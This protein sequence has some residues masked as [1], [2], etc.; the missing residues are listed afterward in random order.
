MNTT[1]L[2]STLLTCFLATGIGFLV[3][4]QVAAFSLENTFAF[5]LKPASSFPCDSVVSP[6]LGYVVGVLNQDSTA[7]SLFI[8]HD[9]SE[10]SVVSVDVR[11]GDPC[12][13]GAALFVTPLG[14]SPLAVEWQLAA[15]DLAQLVSGNLF[16]AI[17]SP[18][19]PNG[20][21]LGR[22]EQKPDPHIFVFNMDG[23]QANNCTSPDGPHT[24]VGAVF[25]NQDSTLI[26]TFMM[27]DI[28]VDSIIYANV[29]E[30]P[31]CVQGVP[32]NIYDPL[33]TAMWEPAILDSD[34]VEYLFK[35]Y[36]FSNIHTLAY[37]GAEIRGQFLK[38]GPYADADGDGISDSDDLCPG[39]A[40]NICCCTVPGD[41]D[42][43]GKTNIADI[44]FLIARI[45]AGGSAPPCCQEGDVN[46]S[47]MVNIADVTFLIARIFAGGT[48]PL[49]GPA[50]MGC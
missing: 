33:D 31:P 35:G 13:T 46:R 43:S 24:G 32:Y 18:D 28:A 7:F 23:P 6:H 10:D 39:D 19:F 27:H 3:H 49:C 16:V 48:A 25:L 41:A 21:I 14:A 42:N 37:P 50:G 15:G 44:T 11:T 22:I 9:L 12:D 1:L 34:G 20:E 29:H 38:Q 17:I 45:F 4:S 26:E 8:N 36:L 47:G 40:L 30:G 5:T 2:K